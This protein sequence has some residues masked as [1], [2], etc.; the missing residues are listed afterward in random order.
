MAKAGFAQRDERPLLDA[1]AEIERLGIG[2]HFA[3]VADRLEIARDDLVERRPVRASDLD[4]SIARRR[5][6]DLGDY[7]SDVLRRDRL[8][9]TGRD[10]NRTAF[11]IRIGDVG[12]EF[13]ELGGADDG[14][15]DAGGR[16][17][18]F[19]GDLGAEVAVVAA[20]DSD[21]GQ[22]NMMPDA[23]DSLGRQ[24]IAPGGLEEFE[25][26]LVL[27]RGR[28]GE[29]DNRFSSD[30]GHREALA[31]DAVDAVPGRSGEDLVAAL[32]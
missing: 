8:E 31:G 9:Q 26:R 21:D 14:I 7:C 24:K 5:E 27:E 11:R 10:V 32:T 1:A 29:V 25:H 6:R 3:W 4:D 18:P 15:R 23:R 12:K 30:H 13:H 28:I 16:Y 2:R 20:V 22:S 17:Q 19:L